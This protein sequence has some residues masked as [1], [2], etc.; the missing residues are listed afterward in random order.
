MSN[1]VESVNPKKV[2]LALVLSET[3]QPVDAISCLTFF[4]VSLGRVRR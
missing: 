3:I 4:L 2:R 1:V